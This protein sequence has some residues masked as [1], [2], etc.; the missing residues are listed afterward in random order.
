[1]L[2]GYTKTIQM[3][4]WSQ[5]LLA[6]LLVAGCLAIVG[7]QTFASL[8]GRKSRIGQCCSKGCGT[9]PTKN[10]PSTPT[11]KVHF[12]PVEMLTRRK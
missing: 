5:H 7:W 2:A 11:Q 1:M 4:L 10:A 12:M 3:P 6:L 8:L 9:E